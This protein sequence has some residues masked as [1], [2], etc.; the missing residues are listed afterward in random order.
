MVDS[1]PYQK[2]VIKSKIPYILA[3]QL[4]WKPMLG[5][6]KPLINAV[7]LTHQLTRMVALAWF[8]YDFG[9]YDLLVHNHLAIDPN[10]T[11]T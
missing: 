4:Y 5:T 8:C 7:V 2:Y 9:A 10:N 1:T 6:C 11:L 3:L